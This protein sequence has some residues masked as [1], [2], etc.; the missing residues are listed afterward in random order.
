MALLQFDTVTVT[1]SGAN[2]PTI[3]VGAEASINLFDAKITN[4]TTSEYIKFKAACPVN[5]A[6]TIDTESKSAYLP[7][8]R[9]I[10]ITFSSNRNDW[11]NLNPG[12]NTLQWDDVGTV[13]VTITVAHR[14]KNL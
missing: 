7:D 1:F 2:L 5:T 14:D 13:A 8:G 4:N 3:S 9:P 10:A 12:D 11:L 6:L